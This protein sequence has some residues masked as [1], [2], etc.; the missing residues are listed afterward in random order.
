MRFEL[1]HLRRT[2]GVSTVASSAG[3]T[4]TSREFLDHQNKVLTARHVFLCN[5][6]QAQCETMT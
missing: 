4:I 1:D 3:Y 5:V 2:V 6:E